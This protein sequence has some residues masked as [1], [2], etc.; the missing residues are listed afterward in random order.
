MRNNQPVSSRERTF[1]P[2]SRLISVTDLKGNI[3]DCNDAFVEISGF[4]R[5][6]LIGQP[7]NLV[8]HPD[9]PP[10]AFTVMWSH[11]KAGK[12][13]MGLVKNRCKNGDFYW[14]DAY[15]TPVTELG[16]IVGYESVRSCPRRPD[17]ER[18]ERLYK[19]LRL[20]KNQN[21]PKLSAA[22]LLVVATL[23][24]FLILLLVQQSTAALS[25]LSIGLA[26]LLLKFRAQRRRTLSSLQS[27]LVKSFSHPLAAKTYSDDSE[28]LALLQVA[29]LSQQAH[30]NTVITRI[31][32]AAV[33]VARETRSGYQL[34]Q[35]TLADIEKQQSE[36]F[37]VATAMN[38]MS[39]TIAEVACHVN[40]TAGQAEIANQLAQQGNDIA[41]S[42][43]DAIENLR[44]TVLSI[45]TAVSQVSAETT[46]IA[47]AAQ[48]IEQIADQTNLLA[49]NA[50]IEAARAGEAGRGF[51]VVADEV[52]NLAQRTQTSTREIFQIVQSL[53][54][55]ASVAVSSAELGNTAAA[56]GLEK[57]VSSADMLKGI[58][59]AVQKIT[60]MSAQMAAAVEEQSHVSEDINR[61]VVSIADLAATSAVSAKSM[62]DAMTTL[63][64]E[65]DELHELVVRF[66]R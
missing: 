25:V 12:A 29:I 57:V 53:S 17:V 14:V 59:A 39:T 31:E 4:S 66:R 42:T 33:N 63:R 34:T 15:V 30:L 44:D 24:F 49:L 9:M 47:A 5:Q 26:F 40:E 28:E 51:S 36:T 20:G 19:M 62:A 48:I 43:R 1:D 10:E 55:G 7:H 35:Q 50:A 41:D 52:R 56:D 65:S 22:A 16:K 2:E 6:E 60:D 54:I 45:G 38:Q 21:P 27:L 37:L 46:R 64:D 8:R 18:A 13:W 32:N 61:Q 3:L 23:I 58:S 11:L